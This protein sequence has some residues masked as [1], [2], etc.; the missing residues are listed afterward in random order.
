[1]I[2][3]QTSEEITAAQSL[4]QKSELRSV[5]LRQCHVSL[6]GSEQVLTRPF[7]LKLS[8]NTTANAILDGILGIEVRYQIQ[9]YDS[10]EPPSLLFNIE[11]AFQVDYEIKDETF[12]PTSESI[13][14]FKDGNAVFNTW[15]YAR[16]FAQSM[17]S[18]MG[19]H[20]PPMPLLRIVPKRKEKPQTS[21]PVFEPSP[22]K[23]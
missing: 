21:A 15:A 14:A 4:Q 1:M 23:G 2:I 22:A 8:H 19:V 20:P 5:I 16:E 17:T 18:R 6:E 11:C 10:S 13:A 3:S 12:T 9:S 7:F